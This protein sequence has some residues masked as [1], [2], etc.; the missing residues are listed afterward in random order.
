M[1]SSNCRQEAK[2][3]LTPKSSILKILS[4][5]E[6]EPLSHIVTYSNMRFRDTKYTTH[7]RK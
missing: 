7:D 4:I 5:T 6:W 2:K 1:V 3:V